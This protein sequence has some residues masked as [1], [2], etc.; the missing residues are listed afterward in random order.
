MKMTLDLPAPL[1]RRAAATAASRGQSL[2]EFVSDALRNKLAREA[3]HATV[4]A[5]AWMAGFGALKRLRKETARVQS[6]IDQAFGFD[7]R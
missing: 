6:R 2:N 3:M 1:L 4:A 5:P 7:D